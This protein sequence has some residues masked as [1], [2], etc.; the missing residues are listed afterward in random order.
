MICANGIIT[1]NV[2]LGAS[3]LVNICCV[4][5]HDA[6]EQQPRSGLRVTVAGNV[7]IEEDATLHTHTTALPGEHLCSRS[8]VG[9]GAVVFEDVRTNTTVV[10]EPARKLA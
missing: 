2:R 4:I 6:G 3:T 10:G 8:I 5:A 1:T 9:A 7:T